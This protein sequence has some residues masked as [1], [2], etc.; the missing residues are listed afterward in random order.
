M[1]VLI[2][3]SKQVTTAAYAILALRC[4]FHSETP[5]A[6]AVTAVLH[7]CCAPLLGYDANSGRLNAIDLTT[8]GPEDR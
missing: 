5:A 1:D 6:V 7:V 8:C 2:S 4:L 3:C